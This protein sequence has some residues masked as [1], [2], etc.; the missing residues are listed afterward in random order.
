ML[1]HI[2]QDKRGNTPLHLACQENQLDV[3]KALAAAKKMRQPTNMDP[4]NHSLLTPLHLAC[5][6]GHLD[7]VRYLLS[8]NA[9]FPTSAKVDF[10]KGADKTPLFALAESGDPNNKSNYYYQVKDLF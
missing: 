9:N 8:Q 7:V 3:V 6:S 2:L 4:L 10:M 1:S 5:A